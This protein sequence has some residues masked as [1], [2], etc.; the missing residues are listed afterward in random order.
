MAVVFN[1]DILLDNEAFIVAAGRL[2]ELSKNMQELRKE[3][4]NLLEELKVGFDTPAGKKIYNSCRNN[5]LQPMDDQV[6]VISH[7][8]ENLLNAKNSYQSVFN[9]FE[10][11]NNIIK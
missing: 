3:I 8:S 1:K 5:L 2:D 6:R 11:L 10:A 9:E 4:S 7:V